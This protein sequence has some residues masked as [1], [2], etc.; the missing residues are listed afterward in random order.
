M[1]SKNNSLLP[2]NYSLYV[3]D[4]GGYPFQMVDKSITQVVLVGYS[5]DTVAIIT[6]RLH[7]IKHAPLP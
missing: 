3:G 1:L 6:V 4:E 2:G 7:F 5:N